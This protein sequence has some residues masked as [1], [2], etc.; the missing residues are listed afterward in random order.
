VDGCRPPPQR[1]AVSLAHRSCVAAHLLVVR[2]AFRDESAPRHRQWPPQPCSPRGPSACAERN[3]VLSPGAVLSPETVLS[4]RVC[5]VSPRRVAT[6]RSP[7]CTTHAPPGGWRVRR[8]TARHAWP[9]QPR[10]PCPYR[11]PYCP[12][13]LLLLHY[14]TIR[15]R[16]YE[17]DNQDKNRKMIL[18]VDLRRGST[19]NGH[20][21][22]SPAD[23]GWHAERPCTVWAVA[24]SACAFCT[25]H[26]A[27]PSR[28]RRSKPH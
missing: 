11:A 21:P 18:M 1:L 9:R 23:S 25:A 24:Q 28:P 17:Y 16:G 14:S 8:S 26:C 4:P 19:R 27:R 6:T 15:V 20:H 3:V 22:H 2:L 7:P 5:L 12:P 13:P 10:P